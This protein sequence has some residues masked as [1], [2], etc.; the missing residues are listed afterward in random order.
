MNVT[1]RC[2]DGAPAWPEDLSR[3][4]CIVLR[5]NDEDITL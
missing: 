2:S 3:H 5:E 4:A 1:E